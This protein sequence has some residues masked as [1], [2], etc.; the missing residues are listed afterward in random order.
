MND[1]A[2]PIPFEN[3][4]MNISMSVAVRGNVIIIQWIFET[5]VLKQALVDNK[6]HHKVSSRMDVPKA[7]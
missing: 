3:I 7:H 1:I 6:P 4:S 5:H 2:I